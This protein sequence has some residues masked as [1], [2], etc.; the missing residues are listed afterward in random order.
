MKICEIFSDA[1]ES[2]EISLDLVE[3]ASIKD[4]LRESSFDVKRNPF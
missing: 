3:A 2:R 4:A 1:K